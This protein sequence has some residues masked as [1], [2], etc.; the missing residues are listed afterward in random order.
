MLVFPFIW[1]APIA[2]VLCTTLPIIAV[3]TLVLLPIVKGG[4][5]GALW[6]MRM[7][8]DQASDEVEATEAPAAESRLER[9]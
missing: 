6:A 8:K 7:A 2:L 9:V 3:L 5:I 1:K 4:V